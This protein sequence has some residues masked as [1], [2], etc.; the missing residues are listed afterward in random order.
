[1]GWASAVFVALLVVSLLPINAFTADASGTVAASVWETANRV[2]WIIAVVAFLGL[3]IL[4]GYLAVRGT[5]R[6]LQWL[7]LLGA[8]IGP[9]ACLADAAINVS[10]LNSQF[11]DLLGGLSDIGVDSSFGSWSLEIGFWLSCAVL[12]IGGLAGGWVVLR[13]V[14]PSDRL[15]S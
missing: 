9:A 8:L 1:V 5:G 11:D 14:A 2:W 13:A 12:L 10:H 3:G 15:A 4:A 6:Y 7:A